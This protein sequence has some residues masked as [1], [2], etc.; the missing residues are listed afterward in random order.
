MQQELKVQLPLQ[1][2]C[3]EEGCSEQ[4][5]A[6]FLPDNETDTPNYY[7]CYK[8]AKDNGFCYGCGSFWGGVEEFEFAPYWGN[9][10]GYCPHCSDEIKTNLGEYDEEDEDYMD[11]DVP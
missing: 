8:H 3:Q 5:S 4:G 7:Y 10:K 9:I 2:S 6:C 11:W 1:H